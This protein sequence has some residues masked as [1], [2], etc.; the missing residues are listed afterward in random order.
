MGILYILQ[1]R[2]TG[3]YYIGSSNDLNRRLSEHKRAHSLATRGRGLWELVYQESFATLAAAR[4]R[5]YEIKAW[6]SSKRIAI[7]IAGN[8]G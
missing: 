6:K 2:T 8:V 7:L 5:E 3:K 1:S 4:K